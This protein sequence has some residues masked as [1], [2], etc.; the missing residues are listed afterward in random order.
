[1]LEKN[2]WIYMVAP[3]QQFVN[4]SFPTFPDILSTSVN[5]SF[6][7]VA[8]GQSTRD[9]HIKKKIFHGWIQVV[10]WNIDLLNNCFLY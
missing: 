4:Q 9:T 5:T 8:N 2:P 1:M 10:I 6:G 7:Y 3:Y